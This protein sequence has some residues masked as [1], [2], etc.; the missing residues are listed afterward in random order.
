MPRAP[1]NGSSASSRSNLQPNILALLSAE[2]GDLGGLTGGQLLQRLQEAAAN[3][4]D[5]NAG[6]YD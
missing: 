3:P 4:N 2:L 5:E 1:S 6:A